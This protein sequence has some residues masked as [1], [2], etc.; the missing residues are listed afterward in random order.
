MSLQESSRDDLN[1]VLMFC[2][3]R[4]S[5]TT[6]SNS[7]KNL[8]KN[9]VIGTAHGK[10]LLREY[11]DFISLVAVFLVVVFMPL[12]ACFHKLSQL[13]CFLANF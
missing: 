9:S 5:Q 13:H 11:E 4:K 12:V 3:Q 10:M 1:F 8:K 6:C 7:N 2:Q